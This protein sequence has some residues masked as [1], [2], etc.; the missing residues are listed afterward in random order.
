MNN[1]LVNVV[2]YSRGIV[3]NNK[4]RDSNVISVFPIA[5]FQA[6]DGELVDIVEDY[7]AEFRDSFGRKSRVKVNTATTIKAT[8]RTSNPNL[9]MPP[10]VRRG[11]E[12][13]LYWEKG[14]DTYY[15]ETVTNDKNYQKRETVIYGYSD[16]S[17]E[18]V[19]HVRDPNATWTH[20]FDTHGKKVIFAHTTTSDN[21]KYAYDA[22]I[23]VK[24]GRYRV[25]DNVGNIIAMDSANN[26]ILLKTASGA[27]FE[28]NKED[29][30]IRCRN[31]NGQAS[32]TWTMNGDNRMESNTTTYD[33][34]ASAGLNTTTP[35]HN[36][37]GNYAITGGFT[38]SPGSGGSGMEINGTIRTTQDFIAQGISFLTHWHQGYHGPTST[39][40]A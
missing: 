32:D 5:I 36:Q 38:S 23:D 20:G 10:D 8:W 29:I 19:D 15:W 31:F 27:Y 28:I 6:H 3:A 4:A 18:S 22:D 16:T 35:V 14:T 9:M 24:E 34:K 11:A 39:P 7:V 1:E 2:P 13:Q 17:D 21:E 37:T 40:K 26:I 30:N 33:I 12:V 25:E